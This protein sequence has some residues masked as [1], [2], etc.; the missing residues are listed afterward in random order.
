[1]KFHDPM[2]FAFFFPRQKKTKTNPI[3]QKIEITETKTGI[4]T[5]G[6][7]LIITKEI[8]VIKNRLY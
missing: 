4:R 1:M 2:T 7:D 8:P 3:L 5:E 6:I